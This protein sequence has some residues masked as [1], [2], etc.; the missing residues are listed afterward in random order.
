MDETIDMVVIKQ[1]QRYQVLLALWKATGGKELERVNFME[2][3]KNV[4]FGQETCKEILVYLTREGF[5]ELRDFGGGVTLSHKAI[6][7]IER[8]LTNPTEA[9]EHFSTTVIQNFNAPVGAVQ[10]G[11]NS[12]ANVAQNFGSNLSEV[13]ALIAQLREQL[14]SLPSDVRQDAMDLVEGLDEEVQKPSPSKGKIRALL[15]QLAISAGQTAATGAV[16][17][18]VDSIAKYLGLQ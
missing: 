4:G 16:T 3:A 13:M 12:T 15:G 9:T 10:T 11:P 7:E 6:V 2:I 5:F 18:L 1:K 17:V 8:S 14:S